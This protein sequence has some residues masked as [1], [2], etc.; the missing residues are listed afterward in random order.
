MPW[1]KQREEL[2]RRQ[3]LAEKMDGKEMLARQRHQAK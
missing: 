1:N 2:K 3:A